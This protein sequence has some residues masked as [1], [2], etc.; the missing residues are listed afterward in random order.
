MDN[1]TA[2][3]TLDRE[4]CSREDKIDLLIFTEGGIEM[5]AFHP[6]YVVDE[7]QCPKAVLLPVAE[8]EQIVED[9]DELDDIRAYDAAKSSPQEAVALEQAVRE[10]QEG[11]D[12]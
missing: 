5:V 3:Q 10:I 12:A 8:W 7:N 2:E 11:Q 1:S 6:Q 4:A 9:L